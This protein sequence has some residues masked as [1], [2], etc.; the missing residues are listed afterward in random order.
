MLTIHDLETHYRNLDTD[1]LNI[2]LEIHNIVA[3]VAPSAALDFHRRGL[4]YFN[5]AR[6]G[7]VSAGICQTCIMT[8]HIRLAFI[9]GACIPDPQ[10]LLVG[11]TYPKR[12]MR[13]DSFDSAPWEYI[14]DLITAHN[15]FDPYTWSGSRSD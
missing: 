11:K 5:P 15:A 12:Y 2:I 14:K 7:H 9:H 10:R 8:D 6:G 13:I 1:R 4:T 3:E